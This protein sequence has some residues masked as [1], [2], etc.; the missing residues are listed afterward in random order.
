MFIYPTIDSY[1]VVYVETD[2]WLFTDSLSDCIKNHIA[3]YPDIKV[4]SNIGSYL[5]NKKGATKGGY[6]L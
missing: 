2:R 3:F 5:I 6:V 4:G 1:H